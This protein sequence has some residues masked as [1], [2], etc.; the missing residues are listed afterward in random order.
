VVPA[1]L[2]NAAGEF[3]KFTRRVASATRSQT[4]LQVGRTRNS[5]EITRGY[6]GIR[7]AAPVENIPQPTT[8]KIRSNSSAGTG[9]FLRHQKKNART[10]T[11]KMVTISLTLYAKHVEYKEEKIKV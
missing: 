2:G 9:H 4:A 11:E 8:I 5:E 1:A 10:M 7:S 6:Q 3:H